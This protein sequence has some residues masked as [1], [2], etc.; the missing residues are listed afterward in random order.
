MRQLYAR[1]SAPLF[2]IASKILQ[3]SQDAEDVLQTTFLQIWKGAGKYD[4]GRCSPFTWLVMI[5]RSRAIDRLR[6]QQRHGRLITEAAEA[7]PDEPANPTP[8]K[9][10]AEQE[11]RDAIRAA[12]GSIPVN[13]REAI[14]MAFFQGLTQTEISE[15]LRE[16]LGTIKARVRR[17]LLRLREGMHRHV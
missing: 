2:S 16:P 13:Q 15:R 10:A 4:P 3:N 17:G 11:K 7:E 6:Q 8:D 1:F 9:N 14:E 5:T 12:L